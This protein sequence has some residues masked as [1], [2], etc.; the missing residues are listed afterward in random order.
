MM[1]E[2]YSFGKIMIDGEE[3]TED[4]IIFPDRVKSSWWRKKGHE[5]QAEDLDSAIESEPEVLVV[6]TGAHGRMSITEKVRELIESE[7]IDLI[8]ETTGEASKIYNE[9]SGEKE[10]VAALHLT[11]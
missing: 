10:T 5:L 7:G 8:V 2:S 6:G 1:I 9:I 4:V 11:C 3:Y